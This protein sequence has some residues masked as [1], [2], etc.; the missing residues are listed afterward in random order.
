MM[1]PKCYA[2]QRNQGLSPKSSMCKTSV[3]I[4]KL[5]RWRNYPCLFM[6]NV[7]DLLYFDG[8]YLQF[9]LIPDKFAIGIPL[10]CKRLSF[11]ERIT[12]SC[13]LKGH[14]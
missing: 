12:M 4:H 13:R 8:F 9:S 5:T 11:K 6:A 10:G 1:P 14:F 2:N 3:I 7:Y